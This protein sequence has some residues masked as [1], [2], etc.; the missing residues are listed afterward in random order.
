M[1]TIIFQ[2]I[3]LSII[4]LF[5]RP[6]FYGFL[7]L[8]SCHL[9]VYFNGPLFVV[10]LLAFIL[11]VEIVTSFLGC[12]HSLNKSGTKVRSCLTIYWKLQCIWKLTPNVQ[13]A[14]LSSVSSSLCICWSEPPRFWYFWSVHWSF[15]EFKVFFHYQY[16]DKKTG[17]E[18][19]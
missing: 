16:I 17:D 3:I 12:K 7:F 6:T 4:S 8:L 18:N 13:S 10:I 15:L 11:V 5:Q 1:W 19:N 9:L 14:F 2:F